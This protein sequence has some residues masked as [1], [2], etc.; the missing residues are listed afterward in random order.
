MRRYR[1]KI[2]WSR[3]S[4]RQIMS[5]GFI[6][7]FKDLV[8]WHNISRAQKLSPEFMI[9]FKDYVDWSAISKYQRLSMDDIYSL[10]EYIDFKIISIYQRLSDEFI[11]DNS[12]KLD[13]N[14]IANYQKLRHD[15]IRLLKLNIRS[16]NLNY[17]SIE[18]KKNILKDFD[19][20]DDY[21][22]CYKVISKNNT[23]WRRSNLID[24]SKKIC[25]SHSSAYIVDFLVGHFGLFCWLD[26]AGVK[27]HIDYAPY[28][29]NFIKVI[30]LKIKL[31][32]ITS[33]ILDG[34][35]DGEDWLPHVVASKIEVVDDITHKFV[36]DTGYKYT[37]DN[38]IKDHDEIL[39]LC[40]QETLIKSFH[41]DCDKYNFLNWEIISE[42]Q[43]LSE[44]TMRRY[45]DKIDWSL[46]SRLQVMSERFIE[47]F[48]DVVDWDEISK[49]Q[50]MSVGFMM[51]FKD[52][53][54]WKHISRYQTLSLDDLWLM[55]G[56]LDL[57]MVS[58][59]QELDDEFISIMRHRLDMDSIY[60]YQKI[61][62][63]TARL[64]GMKINSTSWKNKPNSYKKN[65]LNQFEIHDNYI[66]AYKVVLSNYYPRNIKSGL[67]NYNVGNV[68]RRHS[69]TQLTS[70]KEDHFGLFCWLT[71]D[72]ASWHIERK[73][74]RV[75]FSKV[76]KV[77]INYEDISYFQMTNYRDEPPQ[78]V[79][80]KLEVVGDVSE[81]F[82]S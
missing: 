50:H 14:A 43:I 30:K 61:N 66:I 34:Y 35:I 76:V 69:T 13:M 78:I 67:L 20:G 63:D 7:E 60:R 22:I 3:C 72:G 17:K 36:Y 65:I 71:P 64:L 6:E 80:S 58:Q 53:V 29:K 2:N 9:K 40:G 79:A 74:D 47:E 27:W 46:C 82:I 38:N 32:D 77:K 68:C 39:K 37:V 73:L 48:K 42:Y 44:S 16:D 12:G 5:E 25:E 26:H 21:I 11:I 70:I 1:D 56:Y 10:Y 41:I 75:N 57:S 59:Y 23:S 52:R 33:I 54:N 4:N 18:Y 19:C 51:K 49:S 31:E 45:S 8:D 62:E 81:D 55:I 28:R 15:T 24:Y